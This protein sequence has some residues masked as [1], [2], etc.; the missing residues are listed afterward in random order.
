MYESQ[1]TEY[2]FEI[3]KLNKELRR[4]PY[5]CEAGCEQCENNFC[6]KCD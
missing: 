4:E 6:I 2:K 5:E 1:I 3:D